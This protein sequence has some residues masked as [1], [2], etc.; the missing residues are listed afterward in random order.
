MDPTLC[1]PIYIKMKLL[2]V[3]NE[4]STYQCRELQQKRA[5]IETILLAKTVQNAKEMIIQEKPDIIICETDLPDG[6]G[7]ALLEWIRAN[8]GE[9][10][11]VIFYSRNASFSYAQ[12]AIRL[13]A[14]DYILKPDQRET[15]NETIGKA[16][17]HRRKLLDE[18]NQHVYLSKKERALEEKFYRAII[19]GTIPGDKQ[20]IEKMIQNLQLEISSD[21]LLCIV[22]YDQK[23]GRKISSSLG[24]L[25]YEYCM[26]S[27]A[28]ETFA[29]YANGYVHTIPVRDQYYLT[30]FRRN[31]GQVPVMD[32]QVMKGCAD[33]INHA[34]HKWASTGVNI[35]YHGF[36]AMTE[37][38]D[39]VSILLEMAKRCHALE[40]SYCAEMPAK[41]E[42]AHI[43][44]KNINLCY[45]V[46]LAA[47]RK[48]LAAA[49]DDIFAEMEA[50]EDYGY[51]QLE[52]IYLEYKKM[53]NAVM[54]IKNINL[55]ILTNDPSYST[56]T[57]QVVNGPSNLYDWISFIN[58]II[59][60]III[61]SDTGNIPEKVKSFIQAHIDE[62]ITRRM[63]AEHVFLNEDYLSRLFRK[64]EGVSLSQYIL[65]VKIAQ[66]KEWL[67]DPSVSVT[68][69]S[70]KIGISNF[71][72]FSQLFK[73]QTGFSPSEYRRTLFHE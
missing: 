32:A 69:A 39:Q 22:L 36:C 46:L 12:S 28:T 67:E 31:N 2:F 57:R 62:N 60:A 54:D 34:I 48:E 9:K 49:I 19:D 63:L 27:V 45:Q 23:Q 29:P 24:K 68:E 3:D 66:A 73:K 4:I 5:E 53:V 33:K 58:D 35:F 8:I 16:V 51:Y 41:V 20:K 44:S 1:P 18:E 71:S 59:I 7:I 42:I 15:L 56:L 72:Y 26:K 55:A 38:K 10:Q 65:N 37:C 17:E 11:V 13:N 14:F 25:E 40:N 61:D 43:Y 47:N 70:K 50:R 21:S 6:S 52:A 64:A 30:M